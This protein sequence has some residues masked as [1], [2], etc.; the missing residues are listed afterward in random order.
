MVNHFF[1]MTKSKDIP[2][3]LAT[4]CMIKFC[5]SQDNFF[6]IPWGAWT[7][8]PSRPF[9]R[10][11]PDRQTISSNIFLP[12]LIC[13][14]PV[15][16]DDRQ[17]ITSNIFAFFKVEFAFFQF[18]LMTSKPWHPLFLAF[19]HLNWQK[20]MT[21]T[22]TIP[23][24]GWHPG[25]TGAPPHPSRSVPVSRCTAVPV[26]RCAS[27]S[28]ARCVSVSIARCHCAFHSV[29]TRVASAPLATQPATTPRLCPDNFAKHAFNTLRCMGTGPLSSN[30]PC[31][32]KLPVCPDHFP[33]LFPDPLPAAQKKHLVA[34]REAQ[35]G[36]G[37]RAPLSRGPP[38]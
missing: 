6:I 2:V 19:I 13:F 36:P 8:S 20:T 25:S 7:L 38:P 23:R 22:P 16:F 17:S 28:V 15:Y 34:A 35:V 1:W 18:T 9:S 26:A 12:S 14:L 5:Q 11:T 21:T 4:L 30:P 29:R 31:S 3:E 24:D 37:R 33:P 32:P 27:V 10:L